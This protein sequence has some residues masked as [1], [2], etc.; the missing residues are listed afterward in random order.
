MSP[1]GKIAVK[2]PGCVDQL[3]AA[4]ILALVVEV[5]DAVTDSVDT[6][7]AI[8]N[9]VTDALDTESK[10]PWTATTTAI[11]AR[12]TKCGLAKNDK[13]LVHVTYVN[14]DKK[15]MT[16]ADVWKVQ[17]TDNEEDFR[18]EVGATVKLLMQPAHALKPKLPT[19]KIRCKD[20]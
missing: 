7:F 19:L 10:V 16:I 11:T 8:R 1:S 20:S 3:L 15:E 18:K 12:L 14:P 5:K 4:G 9:H 13:A 2:V 17:L 6:G